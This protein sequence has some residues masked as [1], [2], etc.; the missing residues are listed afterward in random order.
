MIGVEVEIGGSD[1]I[2]V[3]VGISGTEVEINEIEVEVEINETEVEVGINKT[4]AEVGIDVTEVE[5]DAIEVEID[6]IEVEI[7]VIEVETDTDVDP[8]TIDTTDLGD[9]E[10]E[11]QNTNKKIGI[12]VGIA[13]EKSKK[14]GNPLKLLKI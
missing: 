8:R 6:K 12:E 2:E 5:T 1:V 3:G 13:T 14:K 9:Q 7:N 10:I 11:T 4:S